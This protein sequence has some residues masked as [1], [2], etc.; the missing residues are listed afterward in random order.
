MIK[1]FKIGL[2]YFKNISKDGG[3]GAGSFK[4]VMIEIKVESYEL[5]RGMLFPGKVLNLNSNLQQNGY[6]GRVHLR[7]LKILSLALKLSLKIYL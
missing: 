3:N 7:S 2:I 6:F 5:S 1:I 4:L